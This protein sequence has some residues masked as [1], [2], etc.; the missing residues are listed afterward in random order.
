MFSF[1]FEYRCQKKAWEN[2]LEVPDSSVWFILNCTA[3]KLGKGHNKNNWVLLHPPY[4]IILAILRTTVCLFQWP[5]A[6]TAWACGRWCMTGTARV[7]SLFRYIFFEIILEIS[8]LFIR[9]WEQTNFSKTRPWKQ[10]AENLPLLSN[11]LLPPYRSWVCS[12]QPHYFDSVSLVAK[13][14]CGI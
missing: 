9:T 8:C 10:P 6:H 1:R 13:D 7:W 5:R 3:T 4:A 11:L 14:L 12:Y 2:S